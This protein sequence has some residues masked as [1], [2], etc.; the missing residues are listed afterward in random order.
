M[1]KSIKQSRIAE[2]FAALKAKNQCAFVAYICAGD[3]DYKTSFSALKSLPN[4]GVDIIEIGVPFLDPSGDGPIIE[5]A[6]KRAIAAG[7]TLHK[8]LAMIYEFR[9]NDSKTPVIL[10]SY[11]NPILKFGIAKFFA[12]AAEN[13]VDGVLIV[14]LPLEEEGEI[15]KAY[16]D[17]QI[18]LI[19]LVAPST[20]EERAKKIAKKASGFLYLI[21]LMGTTGT[22]KAKLDSNIKNLKILQQ[23]SPL[24]VVVG[25]GIQ[26]AKQAQE[27]AK[28]GADGVVVGSA[29]VAQMAGEFSSKQLLQNFSQ[30]VA[31]F[32]AAIKS[33][34]FNEKL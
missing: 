26:T 8:S 24:P 1:N 10:M 25:F 32:S 5:N 12:N 29:I 21:S 13:G 2:K 16:R 3:P 23:N 30:K 17:N 14:D 19:H 31:E 27:F 15:L 18:D 7:M 34:N 9:K 33:K 28:S 11:F 20:N 6:A 4:L 22:K